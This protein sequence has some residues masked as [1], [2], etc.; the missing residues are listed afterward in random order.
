MK[1]VP[2]LGATDPNA[3]YQDGNPE[4]GTLGSIVPAAAI[5][6]PQREIL[7]VL[8]AAGLTPSDTD[9]TQLL[10]AIRKIIGTQNAE[11]ERLRLLKIGC[12]MYWRSTTLPEGFAWVNG[13]LVLFE[14]W[15][16]FAAVYNAG[17]F[18]GMVLPYDADSAT[19]A[20]NLGKFRPNAANPTGLYLP[21]CG[22]QFFRAWGAGTSGEAGSW[23]ADTG[24]ELT[25]DQTFTSAANGWTAYGYGAFGESDKTFNTMAMTGGTMSQTS[26]YNFRASRAWGAEHTGTEFSP[27][28]VSIPA[29]LYLGRSS[30][31]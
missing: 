26:A 1:Y 21:S 7:N 5:E 18:S 3:S 2:P 9:L 29:V 25:G 15:P 28:H 20:A 30:E 27:V 17:G 6:R 4:A 24:R 10:A 14:D 16:E 12:P 23:Q 22:E 19:I 11:L 8:T 31:V 13:D